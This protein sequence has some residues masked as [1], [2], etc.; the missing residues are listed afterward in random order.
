MVVTIPFMVQRIRIQTQN[1]LRGM[2]ASEMKSLRYAKRRTEYTTICIKFFIYIKN[3]KFLPSVA[4]TEIIRKRI[5]DG[6]LPNKYC[7]VNR[8]PERQRKR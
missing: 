3:Y 2:K 6:R 5:R 8:P 7:F 1:D 4:N